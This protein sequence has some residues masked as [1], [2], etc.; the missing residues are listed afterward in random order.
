MTTLVEIPFHGTTIHAINDEGKPLVSLRHACE[1]ISVDYSGQLKKL[2]NKSWATV[3]FN[4]TVGQDGKNR[5]MTM[6]DRRTLTM[7]LA[8]IEPSRVKEEA[9]ATLVAFQNEAADV[10]DSYFH[11]GGAVNPRATDTQRA[12]LLSE[13]QQQGQVL[14]VLSSFLSP[15]FLE[16]K[17]KI[18]AARALGEE[19]EIDPLD[20][21]L[22]SEDYL[23]SKG[24]RGQELKSARSYFGRRVSKAY[25]DLHGKKPE[26]A[27][28]EVNGSIRSINAYTE[29]DRDLF[30]QVWEQHYADLYEP[31]LM[32]EL[33]DE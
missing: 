10:L 9:R 19:P 32:E 29:R 8:T 22:H 26:K 18:L 13:I 6:I 12:G 28:H 3:V 17:A 27:T 15:K 21:P 20:L 24:L 30:D 33:E 16:S 23:K 2:R 7:W 4:S 25:Q 5:E 14:Q 1:S 31:S 11:E